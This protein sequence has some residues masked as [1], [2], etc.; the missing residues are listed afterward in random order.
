MI[1]ASCCD[2]IT[3]HPEPG[4]PAPSFYY[5]LFQQAQALEGA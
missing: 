2:H 4:M 5:T 1:H 3:M